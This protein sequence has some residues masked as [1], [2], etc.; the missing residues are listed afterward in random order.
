[1]I[2]SRHGQYKRLGVVDVHQM[3]VKRPLTKSTNRAL[4][5]QLGIC[6]TGPVECC[7]FQ[8]WNERCMGKSAGVCLMYLSR[9]RVP[10]WPVRR[11]AIMISQTKNS[12]RGIVYSL[13]SL[14]LRQPGYRAVARG[15]FKR[16][17]GSGHGQQQQ[18]AG[19]ICSGICIKM[20][21][22]SV[23]AVIYTNVRGPTYILLT[24]VVYIALETIKF[25]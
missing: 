20:L 14:Q 10:L 8:D 23:G 13:L 21:M 11:H 15:A 2:F 22:G 3:G 25:Y 16:C 6:P 19:C 4:C 24:S 1:M 5:A 17:G 18:L 9:Q 12:F 7:H